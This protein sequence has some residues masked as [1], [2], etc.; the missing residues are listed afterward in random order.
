MISFGPLRTEVSDV[1]VI[2]GGGAGCQA[3]IWA[4]RTGDVSVCLVEKGVVGASGCTVM[5]TYSCCAAL[6]HADQR[7]NPH[8][9]FK[10]TLIGGA[11]IAEQALLTKFVED[12][13]S[14]VLELLEYGVPFEKEG[15]RLKQVRIE[16]HTYPRGCFVG[17]RTGQAIQWGLRRKL[18]DIREIRRYNDIQ[19]YRLLHV[20]G[21]VFGAMGLC[22]K[23]LSPI[24]FLARSIII[25]TGGCGQLY[26]H[27]TTSLDNTGDG[28]SI[29]F[30]A[31]AS[32]MDMEFIQFYPISSIYP[33][34]IGMTRVAPTFLKQV[35]GCRI[36][37]RLGQDFVAAKYPQ[38]QNSLN[39][40]VL[41]QL[42]YREIKEG[43]GTNQEGV[44]I[45]V[46]AS[47][48]REMERVLS[49]GNYLK[50]L[51]EMGINLKTTP[52]EIGVA[53]HYL[54]G[55]IQVDENG[56]TNI[57]GLFAAGEAIAGIHGANRLG[58]NA[59]SEILVTGAR[60]GQRAAQFALR[61]KEIP[62]FF[63]KNE[64]DEWIEGLFSRPHAGTP[65]SRL[66]RSLQELMWNYVGVERTGE[67]LIQGLKKLSDFQSALDKELDFRHDF[68]VYHM[69]LHDAIELRLMLGLA[70]TIML[71]AYKREESRGAHLRVDFPEPKAEWVTNLV[72]IK[73]GDDVVCVQKA[74]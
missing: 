41:S 9:H 14:R 70:K 60:A 51:E 31:G 66:K 42:I 73:K 19:I 50:K 47:N 23:T 22:R 35:P 25:A 71:A 37:N 7:D 5:G 59:L 32:L 53:S 36:Y 12:A 46:T 17:M 20:D 65:P 40:D 21:R 27:T 74:K 55:G 52:L 18:R 2:G 3:A 26:S 64:W 8:V 72:L 48:P 56:E 28:L 49:I 13:P 6:G 68:K 29:A 39:R 38:W 63:P 1:L 15:K 43:R 16:G 57:T 34:L 62:T 11:D 69:E 54:M 24:R 45:D 30:E 67:D 33:R 10:D 44:Y 61:Q 58:G 4:Q